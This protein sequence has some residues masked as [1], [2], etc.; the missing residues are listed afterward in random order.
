MITCQ[1]ELWGPDMYPEFAPKPIRYEACERPAT[2]RVVSVWG[3]TDLACAEHASEADAAETTVF[4]LTPDYEAGYEAG[5]AAAQAIVLTEN[6]VAWLCHE[7]ELPMH[8]VPTLP[9]GTD[10]HREGYKWG[11][12]RHLY[13][14]A[15]ERHSADAES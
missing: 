12:S 14:T 8:L 15:G 9:E 3:N 7:D 4:P 11:W 10:E 2:H 1:Y 13:A 6:D 5:G